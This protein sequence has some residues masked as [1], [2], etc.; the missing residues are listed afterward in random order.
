MGVKFQGSLL[1]DSSIKVSPELFECAFDIK[2]VKYVTRA[3]F[4]YL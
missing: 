2:H 1:L 3:I 4:W